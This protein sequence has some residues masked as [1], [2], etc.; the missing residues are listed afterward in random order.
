MG[1]TTTYRC[2]RC[3]LIVELGGHSAFDSNDGYLQVVCSSCGTLH[4]LATR[5]GARMVTALPCPVRTLQPRTMRTPDG[6]TFEVCECAS[7]SD[8]N[9]VSGTAGSVSTVAE[10]TCSH[11]RRGGTMLTLGALLQSPGVPAQA[12][13]P[14]CDGSIE[15]I[16]VSDSI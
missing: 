7:E 11:C 4:R 5:A 9:I 10:M 8:W 3:P 2:G 12:C 15:I 13:C 6:E 1:G 14:L 16:A